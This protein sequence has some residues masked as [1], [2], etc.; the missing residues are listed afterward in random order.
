MLKNKKVLLIL[1]AILAIYIVLLFV[2]KKSIYDIDKA[3]VEYDIS[4]DKI[5]YEYL[6]YLKKQLNPQKLSNFI[7]N[8]YI[9]LENYNKNAN[10]YSVIREM[11]VEG[12]SNLFVSMFDKERVNFDDCPVTEKFRKKFNNNLSS[13]FG[14][15]NEDDAQINCILDYNESKIELKEYSNFK[16]FEP[17]S[18]YNYFFH[19]TIDSEGNVDDVIFDYTE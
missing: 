3:V 14:L 15:M 10:G 16:N 5:K 18:I 19:Y 4:N 12:Y 8:D 2:M 7:D 6:D 17:T 9:Y 13:Y 11:K 1:F